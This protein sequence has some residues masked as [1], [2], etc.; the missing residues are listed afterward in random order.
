VGPVQVI[1]DLENEIWLYDYETSAYINSWRVGGV[2]GYRLGNLMELTGHLGVTGELFNAG[3]A[4][5]SYQQT[6]LRAGVES[7]GSVL[8][9]WLSVEYGHRV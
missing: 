3:T 4:A 6:G 9:G 5:E 8:S 1:L 2:G 7:Y